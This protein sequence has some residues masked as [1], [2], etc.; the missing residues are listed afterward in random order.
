MRNKHERTQREDFIHHPFFSIGRKNYGIDPL[1]IGRFPPLP[2]IHLAD[3]MKG[4]FLPN[5]KVEVFVLVVL[6]SS[7]V[8]FPVSRRRGTVARAS[9][10]GAGLPLPRRRNNQPYLEKE[11]HEGQ[12][13]QRLAKDS[14]FPPARPERKN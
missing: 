14:F 4:A 3:A 13:N 11:E 1:E 12:G 9:S 8:E 10:P 6:V 2:K 5:Q 7:R